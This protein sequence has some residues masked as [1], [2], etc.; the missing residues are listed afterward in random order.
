MALS[1]EI[2]TADLAGTRFAVSPLAETISGLQQLAQPDPSPRVRGWVRWA[3]E[4]LAHRP[5]RLAVTWPLLVSD[6]PAWPQFLL[7]A[8]ATTRTS[9][10]DDLEAMRQTA[11]RDV[12]DSLHRVFG[13]DLPPAAR[14]LAD[15]PTE[16]LAVVA[17]ELREAH[18]QLVR[19]HWPRIQALLETDIAHRA[20]QL[21]S[22]GAARLF[23]DLHRD[24]VWSDGR[25]TVLTDRRDDAV[26]RGGLV[27]LPVAL[28]ADRVIVKG[29]TTTWT[30]L[31][32]PCRGIAALGAVVDQTPA[33]DA[34]VRLLGRSKAGLL[35]ALTAPATTT[36]L[37][38]ELGTTPS[39]VAQ[40]L[41]VLRANGLVSRQ[42]HGRRVVYTTTALG[43]ALLD[44]ASVRSSP[45]PGDGWTGQVRP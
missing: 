38:R 25:L 20:A 12:I 9:I 36:D 44:A 10:D 37:A 22:G 34:T 26:A 4:R 13:N 39:A 11:P 33:P 28:G 21:T 41:A 7:P 15:A 30:T 8:P 43:D 5:L 35:R 23:A 42:R 29:N 6:R 24:V 1:I 3:R 2:G 17:T 31:R 40:H 45:S 18:D 27:L 16:R 32:Y 19:P 14:D